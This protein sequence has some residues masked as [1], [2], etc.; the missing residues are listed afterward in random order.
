VKRHGDCE[1]GGWR[2]PARI[3]MRSQLL[4]AVFHRATLGKRVDQLSM[5]IGDPIR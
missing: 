4:Y 2:Y 3:D 5:T 1:V